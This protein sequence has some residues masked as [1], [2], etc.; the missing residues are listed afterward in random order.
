LRVAIA[1]PA[2]SV[3]GAQPEVRAA[4]VEL[5]RDV[6]RG[7]AT[8][9]SLAKALGVHVTTLCRWEHDGAVAKRLRGAA[10]RSKRGGDS[11]FRMVQVVESCPT[12]GVAVAVMAPGRGLRVAHEPSGL[13]IDGLD[14][15]TLAALLR[16]MA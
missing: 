16:R 15:E 14:V 4:A 6:P 12:A 13:V 3:G 8:A 11:S 7:G 1:A 10:Q 9:G 2:T 5:K